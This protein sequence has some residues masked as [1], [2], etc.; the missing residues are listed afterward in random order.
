MARPHVDGDEGVLVADHERA[1]A[2]DE[3]KAH[4]R[5]APRWDPRDRL[6]RPR[7]GQRD[8]AIVVADGEGPA[9]GIEA[10]AREHR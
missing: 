3:G 8:G 4:D 7:I 9:A 6:E 1:A 5:P 2:R 10:V